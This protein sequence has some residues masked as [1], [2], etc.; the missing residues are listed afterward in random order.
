MVI[1][2]AVMRATVAV[3]RGRRLLVMMVAEELLLLLLL[4]LDLMQCCGCLG[5]ERNERQR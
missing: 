4:L 5:T 2:P 1:V 3:M